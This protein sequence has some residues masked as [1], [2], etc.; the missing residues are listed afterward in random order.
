MVRVWRLLVSALLDWRLPAW[1]ELAWRPLVWRRW[2]EP[3]RV[4]RSVAAVEPLRLAWRPWVDSPPVGG[5][6]LP[7]WRRQVGSEPDVPG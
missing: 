2:D 4:P 1:P 7:V 6:V 3:E 5:L